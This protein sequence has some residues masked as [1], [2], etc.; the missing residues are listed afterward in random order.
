M[1]YR[2]LDRGMD[3]IESDCHCQ[4]QEL[5]LS[6]GKGNSLVLPI[7]G[8]CGCG[9]GGRPPALVA[10]TV[11]VDIAGRHKPTVKIDFSSLI[12][13]KAAS[14]GGRYFLGIIFQLSRFGSN[15]A[16]V[17]LATWIFEKKADNCGADCGCGGV[18]DGAQL[19]QISNS[20]NFAAS[21]CECDNCPSC[22]TYVL[23]VIDFQT[24]F[25][26]FAS[27]TNVTFNAMIG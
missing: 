22:Y 7:G 14:Y 24:A 1:V 12:N 11:N 27:I 26:E 10:G 4:P 16:K 25:I 23:E 21:W 17:P 8:G 19:V 5:I 6:C 13:F 20:E 2:N 15:G 3:P 18:P 9:S